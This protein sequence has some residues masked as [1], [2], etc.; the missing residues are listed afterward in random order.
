MSADP[1]PQ[2]ILATIAGHLALAMQPL[3]AAVADL[4]AFK[5][6]MYRLGWRVQSLP[7][8]YS[9]LGVRVDEIATSLATFQ[10]SPADP[11]PDLV[12]G[13]FDKVQ[14][15]YQ[16]I[17][18]LTEAPV[19]VDPGAFL[20]EIGERLFELLLVDYLA[21]ALPAVYHALSTV[22][23]IA[24]EARAADGERPARLRARLRYDRVRDI[25]SDPTQI[26]RFVYGWGDDDLDTTTLLSH[27]RELLD[28]TG[29][30]T[31]FGRAPRSLVDSYLGPGA[32][33]S[34]LK[35]TALETT[36][37]DTPVELLLSFCFRCRRRER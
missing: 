21:A 10:A 29:A 19:G 23:V 28:H 32:A 20:A 1:H 25:I 17:Q 36:V 34:A 35:L 4:G 22:G 18:G 27:L 24:I 37:G 11:D 2:G 33:R 31:S 6:F 13:L 14:A 30:L 26:P 12:L 7:P 8:A 15:L 3:R 9:S 16:A 5:T